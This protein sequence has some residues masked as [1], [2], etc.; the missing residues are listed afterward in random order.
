MF[1]A[2]GHRGSSFYS[3]VTPPSSRGQKKQVHILPQCCCCLRLNFNASF[4]H[5]LNKKIKTEGSESHRHKSNEAERL[6]ALNCE[7]T[8]ARVWWLGVKCG[9]APGLTELS[10]WHADSWRRS[11][12]FNFNSKSFLHSFVARFRVQATSKFAT[13]KHESSFFKYADFMSLSRRFEL[14]SWKR[15]GKTSHDFL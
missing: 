3:K 15:C 12:A 11:Q 6:G 1:T 14:M 9:G 13:L 10:H 7:T 2:Q 4:Y 8:G 5:K